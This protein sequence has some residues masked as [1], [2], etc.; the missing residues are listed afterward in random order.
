MATTSNI[1]KPSTLSEEQIISRITSGERE[2]FEILLR[3]NNQKLYRVIRSYIKDPF[4]IEDIM[5]NTY[6]K[7]FENLVRFKFQSEFSTWLIRIGI[8]ECLAKLQKRNKLITLPI[9]EHNTIEMPVSTDDPEKETIYNENKYLLETAIDAIDENYRIVYVLKE[10]E[11][12]SIKKIGACLQL[13]EPNVKVKLHRAKKMIKS[14]LL[15][16]TKNT[17]IFEFGDSRC[18]RIVELVMHKI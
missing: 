14:E 11:G 3:R 16:I 6:I 10:I 8:N 7:A 17:S 15:R 2:L 4:D 12:M 18:D 9:D 1:T 13:T 5:Q